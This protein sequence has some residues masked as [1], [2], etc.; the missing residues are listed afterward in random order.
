MIGK[1]S[2]KSLVRYWNNKRLVSLDLAQGRVEVRGI[3]GDAG[4]IGGIISFS[5]AVTIGAYGRMSR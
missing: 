4:K 5:H 2:L 3:V 1:H